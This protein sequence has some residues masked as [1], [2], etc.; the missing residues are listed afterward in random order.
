MTARE[1]VL[2]RI[3]AAFEGRPVRWADDDVLG[4]YD[5]RE[6]TLEVFNADA[7]E[8]LE[9]LHRFRP[10]RPDVEQL[11]GGPVVV[12]FHTTKETARLYAEFIAKHD[13]ERLAV[14][15]R[16]TSELLPEAR[17]E[18]R[19]ADAERRRGLVV[20][21][22]EQRV[23]VECNPKAGFDI[24]LIADASEAADP[25]FHISDPDRASRSI[26][27]LISEEDAQITADLELLP[28]RAAANANSSLED[29]PDLK[30]EDRHVETGMNQPPR[31]AA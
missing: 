11:A 15:A 3:S 18:L 29:P 30:I 16:R 17:L 24:H 25:D 21:L 10:L 31:R 19:A 7:R 5:G 28:E 8:Q 26:A 2:P 14:L 6:R 4:D 12:I 20:G 23:L 1:H 27:L 22:G 13:E 9:L